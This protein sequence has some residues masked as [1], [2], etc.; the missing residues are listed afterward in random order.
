MKG[1]KFLAL[2]MAGAMT[3][4]FAACGN[5]DEGENSSSPVGGEN[6]QQESDPASHRRPR[7][8]LRPQRSQS[9]R[10]RSLRSSIT[11]LSRHPWI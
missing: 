10:V 3:L 6:T 1:K 5:N 11:A 7:I 4:S 2:L 9:P 8:R